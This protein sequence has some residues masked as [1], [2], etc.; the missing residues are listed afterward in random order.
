M[1][2]LTTG[3][4]TE[5]LSADTILELLANRRRR[6]LLYALRGRDDPTE[7]SKLAETVAGWEHDVPPEE[8]AQNEYKSVYVS[9]VQC[10]VP[11]LADAGV[12]DHDED[13][14]TVVLS[15]N[16]EQLEPYLQ[17]VVLDEPKDSTLHA[18]LEAD[19]GEGFIR[20]IR[21]NVARLKP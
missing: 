5:E 11:K 16:F 8:V 13:N 6:Y 15:E 14:H 10:H 4:E 12:V 20:Q 9:S 19:S 18:E 21:E 7:L 3:N 1:A 2:A 17:L